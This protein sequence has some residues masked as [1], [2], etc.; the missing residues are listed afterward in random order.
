VLALDLYGVI[1]LGP[2]SNE[3]RD[4]SG[5]FTC[6]WNEGRDVDES[7]QAPNMGGGFG[8]DDASVTMANEDHVF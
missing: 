4:V 1:E 7:L 6:E 3:S 2:H 5:A 8:D